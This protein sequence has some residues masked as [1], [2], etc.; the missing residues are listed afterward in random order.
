MRFKKALFCLLL[1]SGLVQ[2][3]MAA[4][5]VVANENAVQAAFLYNFALFTEWPALQNNQF[6]IC[7]MASMPVFEALQ[8]FK[9]KQ[10]RGSR[11][12]VSQIQTASEALSC[13]V[14][15]IGQSQHAFIK[16][17]ASQ[18]GKA[19]VLVVAEESSFDPQNVIIT[20]VSQQGRIGFKINNT[21]AQASSLTISSKLLKLAQLVY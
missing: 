9:S 19:P 21:S 18:I 13:Q 20:L 14:L 6:N 2:P 4:N 15:F 11:V 16:N 10:V 12:V 3:A 1:C 8:P 7:V 17:V 5:E